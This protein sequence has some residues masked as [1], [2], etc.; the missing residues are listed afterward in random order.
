[1]SCSQTS[2]QEQW[3]IGWLKTVQ[4]GLNA[5][6]QRRL[7]SIERHAGSLDLV[8]TVAERMDVHLLLVEDDEGNEI[9]AASMRPFR[10]IC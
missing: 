1:M 6:S 2:E 3:V 4:T 5:M 9:V 8:K 10:V 7:M